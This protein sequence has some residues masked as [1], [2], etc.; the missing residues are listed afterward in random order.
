MLLTFCFV[1]RVFIVALSFLLRRFRVRPTARS[2]SHNGYRMRR[3]MFRIMLH[4]LLR[5]RN[6]NCEPP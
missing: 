6:L 1:L 5:G 3:H 2:V 4:Q